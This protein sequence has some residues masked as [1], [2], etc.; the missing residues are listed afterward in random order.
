MKKILTQSIFVII[1]FLLINACNNKQN[2]ENS[3]QKNGNDLTYKLDNTEGKVE[4][5]KQDSDVYLKLVAV[6]GASPKGDVEAKYE[7]ETLL[8]QNEGNAMNQYTNFK[9]CDAKYLELK[10]TK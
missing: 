7:N 2:T 10:K 5:I 4:I 1:G 3:N 9:K 8:I 6:N